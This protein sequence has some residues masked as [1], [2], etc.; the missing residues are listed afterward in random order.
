MRVLATTDGSLLVLHL[1]PLTEM[2]DWREII[3]QRD[4]GYLMWPPGS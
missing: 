2:D 1:N 4:L 3:E